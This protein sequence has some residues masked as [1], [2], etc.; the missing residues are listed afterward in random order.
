MQVKSR[1]SR[2]SC[3]V[4]E[5]SFFIQFGIVKNKNT[6]SFYGIK[7]Q[8][9][10]F[11]EHCI[12][13][14]GHDA[15]SIWGQNFIKYRIDALTAYVFGVNIAL[16]HGLQIIWQATSDEFVSEGVRLM[17]LFFKQYN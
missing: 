17:Y 9:Y 7:I 4:F 12:I 8:S 11:L 13:S 15:H 2:N 3:T 5:K 16:D 10:C 6:H 1:F 14:Y